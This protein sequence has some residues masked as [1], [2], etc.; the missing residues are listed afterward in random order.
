M[1]LQTRNKI[2]N[3][4]RSKQYNVCENIVHVYIISKSNV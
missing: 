2:K 1:L 4:T 3:R